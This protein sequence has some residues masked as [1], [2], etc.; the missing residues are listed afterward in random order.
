MQ[1]ISL[2]LFVAITH[3]YCDNLFFC[4]H[5]HLKFLTNTTLK[6]RQ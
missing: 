5:E 6:S 3:Y 4:N 2:Q 1:G